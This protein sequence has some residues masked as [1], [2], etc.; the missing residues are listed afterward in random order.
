[1]NGVL[2]I[3]EH[4]GARPT[5]GTARLAGAATQLSR[6]RIDIAVLG[7]DTREVAAAAA[8]IASVDRVLRLDRAENW[9]CL[10]A[11]WAPQIAALAVDYSHVLAPATTFGKDL[12]PRVAGLLGLGMLSDITGIEAPD[13]FARPVYAGNAVVR[14]RAAANATVLATVRPTAFAPAPPGGPA[15]IETVTLDIALPGHTRFVERRGSATSGPDLQSARRV[16]AGG[17][18]LGGAE[19][20]ALLERLAAVLGAAVGASRAAVDSGWVANE[21]QVGQTGKII[22]PELY[23]AFGISGA[24][25]HLTGIQDAGTIVAINT[26]PD[27]PI[28]ALA[29]FTL[30]GDLFAILPELIER[31]ADERGA[32]A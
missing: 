10:A 18:G 26:D 16:V 29:D 23:I 7:D 9:P 2:V 24:I 28:C 12:L 3:G 11:V 8:T 5:P 32:C 31:L 13:R 1:M 30:V 22:A 15:A 17:R 21:L 6:E 25:Q 14:V 4:D 19:G 27:A 20:F